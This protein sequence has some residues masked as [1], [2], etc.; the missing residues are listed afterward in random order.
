M[1]KTFLYILL[2]LIISVLTIEMIASA[3]THDYSSGSSVIDAQTK[4]SFANTHDYSS[5][6]SVISTQTE[7]RVFDQGRNDKNNIGKDN[8]NA[9]ILIADKTSVLIADNEKV[10]VPIIPKPPFLP[11]P[12]TGEQEEQGARNILVNVILPY[13]GVGI[14]GF[15]GGFALIFLIVGS[16]RLMTAYGNEE[17]IKKGKDQLMYA[18][19]GLVIGLLSYTIVQIIIRLKFLT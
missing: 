2:S 9:K 12:D 3:N 10:V 14:I 8:S 17:S 18:V 1:K 15:V 11:G 4:T 7:I 16:V 19:I 5:G 13:L 6:N